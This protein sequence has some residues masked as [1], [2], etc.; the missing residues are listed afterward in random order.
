MGAEANIA[1]T[2]DEAQLTED[3]QA[4]GG[5]RNE[6]EGTSNL[7]RPQRLRQA[8]KQL[9]Y[10]SP[11]EPTYVQQVQVD[12]YVEIQQCAIPTPPMP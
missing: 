8:P 12:R 3:P 5:E 9:T 4:V 2:S 1:G 6:Q 11:G 10:D 7:G